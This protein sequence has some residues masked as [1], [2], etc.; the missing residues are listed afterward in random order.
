MPE[1]G[2]IYKLLDW[3][4]LVLVGIT[5]WVMVQ[6]HNRVAKQESKKD[7]HEI[8]LVAAENRMMDE[9]T[10]RAIIKDSLRP[11]N[12]QHTELFAEVR[13]VTTKLGEVN[14]TLEIVRDRMDRD[15]NNNGPV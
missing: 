3:A 1:G 10:V 2:I 8:R 5:G 7:D 9:A 11:L 13:N 14:T 12:V 6:L 4:V 15:P